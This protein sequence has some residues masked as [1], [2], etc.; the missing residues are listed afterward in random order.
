MASI[1]CNKSFSIHPLVIYITKHAF[2]TFD[3]DN[4]TS[5][6]QICLNIMLNMG[7]RECSSTDYYQHKGIR[8]ECYHDRHTPEDL[9]SS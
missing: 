2:I 4:M 5:Y 3:I 9:F 6:N 7:Q 8:Y 1:E